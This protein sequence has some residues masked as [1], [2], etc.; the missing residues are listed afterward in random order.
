VQG[1]GVDGQTLTVEVRLSIN[2]AAAT[3]EQVTSMP[4]PSRTLPL[5]QHKPSSSPSPSPSPSPATTE[6]VVAQR[7]KMLSD[8]ATNFVSEVQGELRG[9]N[10]T[11]FA[12]S[13]T[14]HM[15]QPHDRIRFRSRGMIRSRRPHGGSCSSS[16]T[17]GAL[18]CAH[19]V[20]PALSLWR[21]ALRPPCVSGEQS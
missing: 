15:A 11:G 5:S 12:D 17:D 20:W 6:Q 18:A 9:T 1:D 13:S 2:L 14:R 16:S 4:I 21:A 7:H 8:M 3:I 10:W 19:R